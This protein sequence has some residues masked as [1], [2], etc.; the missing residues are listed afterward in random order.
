VENSGQEHPHTWRTSSILMRFL[1]IK[2]MTRVIF[3][4]LDFAWGF[5]KYIILGV[6][7][8][9]LLSGTSPYLVDVI[10]PPKVS[11]V[12]MMVKVIFIELDFAWG[13]QKYII[14]GV[15]NKVERCTCGYCC[16]YC[17]C[18]TVLYYT[19]LYCSYYAVLY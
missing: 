4:E 2:M 9:K 3:I 11:D 10:H 5:Q 17:T 7:S 13:F 6:L 18:H 19:V 1:I 16:T 15:L 14:L 12:I 8:E